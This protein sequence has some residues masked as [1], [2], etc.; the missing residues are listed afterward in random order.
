M[1]EFKDYNRSVRWG[2]IC[3][4]WLRL[5]SNSYGTDWWS[6]MFFGKWRQIWPRRSIAVF[7]TALLDLDHQETYGD[8]L[9]HQ[10]Y[11]ASYDKVKH[12]R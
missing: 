2:L 5:Y 6:G 1:L 7:L 9:I 4:K 8:K 11:W 12:Q 10:R 3:R